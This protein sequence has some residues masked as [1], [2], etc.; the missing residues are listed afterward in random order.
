MTSH[1][2]LDLF[3]FLRHGIGAARHFAACLARG[4]PTRIAALL[5]VAAPLAAGPAQGEEK[6]ITF[7]EDGFVGPS[8]L[9]AKE[10]PF[11]IGEATFSGGQRVFYNNSTVYGTGENIF[12]RSYCRGC[13]RTLT[14][15]FSEPVSNISFWMKNGYGADAN[16]KIWDDSGHGSTFKLGAYFKEGTQKFVTLP[17][18]GITRIDIKQLTSPH[19]WTF[20]IDD[21]KYTVEDKVK[22]YLINFSAFVP[23]DNVPAGPTASC[24]FKGNSWQPPGLTRLGRSPSGNARWARGD[25]FKPAN[26]RPPPRFG[27]NNQNAESG[28]AGNS[29]KL[30]FAGDNRG[31]HPAAPTYRVRQL[32]TVILDET[33]DADGLLDGSVAN[34]AGEARAFAADAMADGIIDAA[35]EDGIADDCSLFHKAHLAETDLMDVAVTRTG[36]KTLDIRF[37][38]TLD[39]PLAGPAQVLGA[40]DWEFT[41]TLDNTVEPGR[42]TL[43]GAHDGFPAYEIYINGTPVYQHDPGAPPYD[44]ARDVRKLL[45]PLDIAVSGTSGDLP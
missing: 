17:S 28:L 25:G 43:S 1:A 45:P 16:F 4:L 39:S 19:F 26:G 2:K 14:I 3:G 33:M 35:D 9:T 41:L 20:Y 29:R 27:G 5:V 22:K 31:F 10:A 18:S 32:V 36:P 37:S 38:G 42:W 8:S 44:F 21:L 23:H 6:L 15:L 40:I 30:Y 11:T 34:L 24:L 12:K 13:E 7:D